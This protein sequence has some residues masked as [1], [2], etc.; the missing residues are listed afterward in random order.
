MRVFQV[1][2]VRDSKV[3]RLEGGYRQP[4]RG[5]RSRR[6]FGARRS[7]RLLSLR[8]TARAMSQENVETITRL[9]DEFLA[10]PERVSD[11]GIFQFFDPAVELRQSASFLGTEGTF[12]GYDGLARSARELFE[13]FR[14]LHWVPIRLIDGGDHVVATVEARAV[15]QAQ[16]RGGQRKGRARLDTSRRTDRRLARLHGP[17]P[18]P[19]SR[20]AVGARRSRRGVLVGAL[21]VVVG[22]PDRFPLGPASPRSR[23]ARRRGLSS[24]LRRDRLVLQSDARIVEKR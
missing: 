23:K 9:Y 16:R 13:T 4:L 17:D 14:D 7:R 18:G 11:P 12:H 21:G 22:R 10:R 1:W 6:P 2:T 5:P 19:R 8:D 24:R 3:V 20:G 15:R